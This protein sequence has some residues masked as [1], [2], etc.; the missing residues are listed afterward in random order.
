M[1]KT[2]KAFDIRKPITVKLLADL[3]RVLP[4]I[5]SSLYEAKLFSAIFTLAFFAFL[6]IGETVESGLSY[7]VIQRD[8][9]V[10][11]QNNETIT[12]TISSSK[13]DQYGRKTI[14]IIGNSKNHVS[15]Y[16]KMKLYLTVRPTIHGPLFCHFNHKK[17]TRYQVCSVLKSAIK[18]L[19]LNETEY[20][21]HSLRIG[22]ATNA[23]EIGISNDEIMIMGRWKSD[24]YKTYIRIDTSL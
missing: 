15:V 8:E 19:G 18:F 6:R 1:T 4:N 22:A 10:M 7:H 2:H 20:N 24:T 16:E 9:I 17:V 13:T 12:V 23:A 21:T 5:C 3:I 11:N 14:L